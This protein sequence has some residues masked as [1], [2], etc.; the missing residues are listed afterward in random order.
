[1]NK[2]CRDCVY[3]YYD[4]FTSTSLKIC[5]GCQDGSHFVPSIIVTS[6]VQRSDWLHDP[7]IAKQLETTITDAKKIFTLICDLSNIDF[8]QKY[9]GLFYELDAMEDYAHHISETAVPNWLKEGEI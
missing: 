8:K 4:L 9:S 7:Y 5:D 3:A 1:M 6:L 2:L